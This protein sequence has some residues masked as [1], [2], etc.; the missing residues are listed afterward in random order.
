MPYILGKDGGILRSTK[1]NR[2]PVDLYNWLKFESKNEGLSMGEFLNLHLRDI[3]PASSDNRGKRRR[4]DNIPVVVSVSSPSVGELEQWR[5]RY[6]GL[7]SWVHH[8]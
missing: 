1:S 4:K 5:Q 8:E 7:P 6:D 2:I 3:R